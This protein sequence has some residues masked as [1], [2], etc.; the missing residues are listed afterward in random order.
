MALAVRVQR[1]SRAAAEVVQRQGPQVGRVF[2]CSG[3]V[4][5]VQTPA[6]RLL[7]VQGEGPLLTPLALAVAEPVAAL[8]TRLAAGA[9]VGQAPCPPETALCL[10]HAGAVAW[11]G[12]LAPL[13]LPARAYREAACRLTAWLAAQLPARGLAPVLLALAGGRPALAPLAQRVYAVLAPLGQQR[14]VACWLE[15]CTDLVGLGEGLTPAGDD[16]LVGMLAMW[17]AAGLLAGKAALA[18]PWLKTVS[19]RTTALSAE[20]LRCALAGHFAE[21]LGR[22]VRALLAP[23]D[24]PWLPLAQTLAG[25]GHSSGV[26]TLVGVAL[27]ATLVGLREEAAA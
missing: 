10:H 1:W 23:P 26:D 27:G 7:T 4:I 16:L 2:A 22:L 18:A 25:I 5:H 8:A 20:F 3:R 12:Y 11:D 6:G 24:Q 21:P 17:Q 15:A 19:P 13:N 14:E 9:L